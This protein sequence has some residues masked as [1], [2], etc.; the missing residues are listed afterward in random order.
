MS[1]AVTEPLSHDGPEERSHRE[2]LVI[3]SGLMAAMLL[4]ALDQ[5][6][7]STALPTIVGELHGL[8][9]LSWVVTV[10][11][12][13]STAT[14]PLYGK[15]SDLY[16]R[17]RLFQF[18]IG[19]FLIGSALCGLSQNMTQLILF[20]GL[21]GI[22]AGG[23]MVLSMAIIGDVVS[24]RQRG[25]YVG[26]IG[27]VF[28]FASVVGPLL[29][30]LFT[31]HLSWRWIFYINIPVGAMALFIIAAVLHL[32]RARI[33][34]RVDYAGAAVLVA[35]VSCMLL[36]T[37]WG[38]TT[39]AWGS[40]TI[41]ALSIVSAILV[42]L[43][44]LWEARVAEPIL[45]LRLF[46][47]TVFSVTSALGFLVGLALFG[48]I[49]YL[50][51]YLQIVKGTSA[52]RSGLQIIPLMVGLVGAS[53]LS[54]R[55][56]TKIGRYKMFPIMGTAVMTL[57]FWLLSHV[58]VTTSLTML[59]LWMFVLGV[60]VG[61]T[62]QVIVLAVQNAVAYRDMGTATSANT[63]FRTLGGAFGTAVFGAILTARL[64]ASLLHLLPGGASTLSRLNVSV[65]QGAPKAIRALPP[66]ILH[67]VL[68]SYVRAYHVLFLV[69]IPIAFVSFVLALALPEVPLRGGAPVLAAKEADTVMA[70]AE[71]TSVS[72]GGS[73]SSP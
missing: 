63:F 64:T 50:P 53:I 48:A 21:Q 19:V 62:M 18:A 14:M 59:S 12:L 39:Y 46:R 68:E 45:P 25:R 58:L 35:A 56:I 2:I 24:P 49:V 37:V 20:R 70:T 51:Q 41:I 38:G 42:A 5:T 30:G 34:H 13:T 8:S 44:L 23:L 73:S 55:V 72:A 67:P 47:N 33:E 31:D 27:A 3:F 65:L 4:A 32:P 40:S 11:L 43:F 54:G 10:Y 69:A 15:L 16:G 9:H 22:G 57:G 66:T 52:T 61:A 29:G 6:I 71:T 7:V 26:Y 1:Q 17:K 60:G 28:G 36:V